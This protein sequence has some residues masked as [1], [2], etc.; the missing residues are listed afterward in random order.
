[1]GLARTLFARYRHPVADFPA[2]APVGPPLPPGQIVSLT[3]RGETFVRVN[4]GTGRNRPTVLLLHG[5][6]ASADLQWCTAYRALGPYP[7]VAMDHRGHGR[8]IRSEEAFT[9]EAAADDAAAAVRQ[10][11]LGPVIAVGYSM[12]GPVAMLLRQRHPELVSG[13][14]LAA[15]SLEWRASKLDRARWTTMAAVE[16]FFRSRLARRFARR[17]LAVCAVENPD[18]APW[19]SWLMAEL[20]RSDP[21]AL[22]EAG[23]ALG[24]YDAR[25]WAGDLRVA[26]AVLLTADDRLVAPRKQ[27][28]LAAALGADVVEIRGD[29]LAFLAHAEA[30]TDAL[31]Q[32]IELVGS[33]QEKR[34]EDLAG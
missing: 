3:G 32:A 22:R 20:R 9:L 12:G 11:G 2:G 19:M 33:A 6:T 4:P 29:H 15:T 13:L 26:S 5:W 8:G 14:V 27:R 10:L 25:P 7:F 18:L 1:M 30:F 34:S 21:R 28:A 16:G 24:R 23:E 31:V 17:A